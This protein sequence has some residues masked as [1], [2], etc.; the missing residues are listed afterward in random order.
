MREIV[1]SYAQVAAEAADLARILALNICD[2]ARKRTAERCSRATDKAQ[3]MARQTWTRAGDFKREHPVQL[4]GILAGTAFLAGVT[5]RI[6][7]SRSL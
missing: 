2:R 4:L 5:T 7:R 6:W 3:A 1:S